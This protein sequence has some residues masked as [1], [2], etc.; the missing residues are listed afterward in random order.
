MYKGHELTEDRIHAW[1]GPDMRTIRQL[2]QEMRDLH[3]VN[4]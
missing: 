3:Y 2:Y 1:S 4:E